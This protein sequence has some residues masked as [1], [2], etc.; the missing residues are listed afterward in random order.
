M[1]SGLV[2]YASSIVRLTEFYTYVFGLDL[3]EGDN[4]YALLSDGDFELVLLETELSKQTATS[5]QPREST[6][7]KPTYFIESTLSDISK[8]IENKGGYVYPPKN[9][10]FGGRLVCDAYDCEGNIFQLRIGKHAQQP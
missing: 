10:E 9:W 8:R 6:P 5:F 1:K 2:I 7:I 3:L 4:S